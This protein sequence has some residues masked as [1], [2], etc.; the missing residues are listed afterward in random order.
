MVLRR[1]IDARKAVGLGM[2][3]SDAVVSDIAS[4]VISTGG[5]VER[6]PCFDGV[7]HP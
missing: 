2:A 1:E 6:A 7:G 4:G 5:S 3:V